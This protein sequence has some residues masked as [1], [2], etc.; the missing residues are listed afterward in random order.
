MNKDILTGMLMYKG[1]HFSFVFDGTSLKLIPNDD[2]SLF[3]LQYKEIAPGTYSLS[4]IRVEENILKAYCNE[5]QRHV[6]FFLPL[7]DFVQ[8]SGRTLLL[9]P[10]AYLKEEYSKDKIARL[11]FSCPELDIIY[12]VGKGYAMKG[13][14][15]ES[16]EYGVDSEPFDNTTT[17]R[18][19]FTFSHKT[20]TC[21]LSISRNLHYGFRHRAPIEYVSTLFFEFEP[22]DDYMFIYD[23]SCLASKFLDY[24]CNRQ[25]IKFDSIETAALTNDGKYERFAQLQIINNVVPEGYEI[26][27]DRVIPYWSI[28]GYEHEVLQRLSDRTLYLRHIP[29]S[30]HSGKTIDEGSFVMI[31]AAFEWEFKQLYPKGIQKKQKTIDAENEV[32]TELAECI[33]QVTGKKKEIYKQLKRIVGTDNLGDEINH[34]CRDLETLITPFANHLYSLNAVEIKYSDIAERVS[35]QRNNYA[36]GN[37]DKEIIPEVVLD[38]IFLRRVVY[39]MQLK[40]IGVDDQG[41]LNAVNQLFGCHL[42]FD[43]PIKEDK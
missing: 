1:I 17:E 9:K 4:S 42:M 40:T 27:K 19:S 16:G 6:I 41:I 38:I 36:H 22:T 12:P 25:N 28:E 15:S 10:I 30:Y 7:N 24:L 26:T 32:R 21:Y 35:T 33:N 20:I 18:R 34:V 39:I 2:K 29:H 5:S 23:L 14:L 37:I 43:K 8:Q 31:T 11:S 3:D 13:L